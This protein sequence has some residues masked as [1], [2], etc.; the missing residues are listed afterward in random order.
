MTNVDDVVHFLEDGN[1][2]EINMTVLITGAVLF[3]IL[4]LVCTYQLLLWSKTYISNVNTEQNLLERLLG[5]CKVKLDTNSMSTADQ[6]DVKI[7]LKKADAEQLKGNIMKLMRQCKGE[8]EPAE[9]EAFL[10]P[11]C[12]REVMNTRLKRLLPEFEHTVQMDYEKQPKETWFAWL[13]PTFLYLLFAVFA[14]VVGMIYMPKYSKR[15][16]SFK[17]QKESNDLPFLFLKRNTNR[18][19]ML[20]IAGGNFSAHFFYQVFGYGKS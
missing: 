4:V 16:E 2:E 15:R 9:T 14:T 12:K 13:W 5:T 19:H 18:K 8:E 7:V 11:Y 1:S 20:F 3:G 6:T 10:F 17:Q